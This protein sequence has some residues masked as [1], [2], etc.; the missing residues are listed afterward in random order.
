MNVTHLILLV[1]YSIQC[2]LLLWFVFT[3]CITWISL[4]LWRGL[5]LQYLQ[6]YQSQLSS[7]FLGL[8]TQTK[9]HKVGLDGWGCRLYWY[10]T[11]A[12]ITLVTRLEVTQDL[13]VLEPQLS[14]SVGL[15]QPTVRRVKKRCPVLHVPVHRES[16]SWSFSAWS[17]SSCYCGETSKASSFSCAEISSTGH[18]SRNHWG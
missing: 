4:R 12:A 9:K 18:H 1:Q 15:L 5:Y 8:P 11:S 10:N 14:G 13:C 7:G 16:S 6:A 17:S 2:S 3:S